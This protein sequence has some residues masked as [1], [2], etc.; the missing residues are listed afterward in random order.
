MPEFAVISA[1]GDPLQLVLYWALVVLAALLAWFVLAFVFLP[2]Y[3]GLKF[4]IDRVVASVRNWSNE[5]GAMA[6]RI[7][8]GIAMSF[9]RLGGTNEVKVF[10]QNDI[11]SLQ[12]TVGGAKAGV[13]K[14]MKLFRRAAERAAATTGGVPGVLR[15]V[16]DEITRLQTVP[17][18][19]AESIKIAKGRTLAMFRAIVFTLF[20][21]GIV[22]L[23]TVM[24]HE[25][26]KG[27]VPFR[28]PL[29]GFSL[30]VAWAVAAFYT[31]LELVFGFAL[32]KENEKRDEGHGIGPMQI[33]LLFF[34]M[35]AI[36]VEVALYTILSF[37]IQ[38][39][40]P[41]AIAQSMP[42]W[43]NGWLG[44]LGLVIGGGVVLS[45][46]F[47]GA[48]WAE[49]FKGNAV[50]SMRNQARVLSASLDRLPQKLQQLKDA[51]N[52]VQGKLDP[53][54]NDTLV[55]ETD[56]VRT[57][58]ERHVGLLN[59]K[60]DDA[61]QRKYPPVTDASSHEARRFRWKV[62]AFGAGGIVA[63]LGNVLRMTAALNGTEIRDFGPLAPPIFAAVAT[64]LM[65]FAGRV[66]ATT[67]V[68]THTRSSTSD[69][70]R[71]MH[72]I[73]HGLGMA[74][75]GGIVLALL[76]LLFSAWAG[77]NGFRS[78]D[79]GG[80]TSSLA[81]NV[82]TFMVGAFLEDI[83]RGLV[84]FAEAIAR[85]VGGAV[86]ALVAFLGLGAAIVVAALHFLIELIA[87]PALWLMRVFGN[88]KNSTG[89]TQAAQAR[90]LQ[91]Q[92]MPMATPE[93]QMV[94]GEAG[95]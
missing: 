27:F 12:R 8:A 59:A 71:D 7:F 87:A 58:I 49:V 25:F 15:R 39:D 1:S 93:Q 57:E 14:Q 45:G 29:F 35:V 94:G 38:W 90:R 79:V 20:W 67:L 53:T 66:A 31:F 32:E 16:N 41:A 17:Q 52:V 13:T 28:I 83:V 34:I 68:V 54:A 40:W 46:Y 5:L 95:A 70:Q 81:V 19:D 77:T 76:L 75:W 55:R 84:F 82:A 24:L 89:R 26:F 88:R 11:R 72:L 51:V 23:N 4:A 73:G 37:E 30:E 64:I 69:D 47:M 74:Q 91:Q 86:T 36:A 2:F 61:E 44:L 9:G 92:T 21:L 63:V 62:L 18:L 43:A 85:T 3:F 80:L 6:R 56:K 50:L 22:G 65:L 78:M 48:Q 10:L 33:V 60:L 42:A